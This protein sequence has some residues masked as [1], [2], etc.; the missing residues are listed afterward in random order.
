VS[1]ARNALNDDGVVFVAE[2]RAADRFE[3]NVDNPYARIGYA[4]STLVCTPSSL[5]QPGMLGLGAMAGPAR[6]QQVLAE[7]GLGTVRR[8]PTEI[9]PFNL[10]FEAR[11]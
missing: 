1:H 5:S 6:I 9:A 4:I 10:L 8:L 7:G 11:P 2:P 3:D